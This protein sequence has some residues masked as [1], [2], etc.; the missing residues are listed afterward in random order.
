MIGTEI[1]RHLDEETVFGAKV[2]YLNPAFGVCLEFPRHWQPRTGYGDVAGIPESYGG[3]DGFFLVNVMNGEGWTP[4]E[5]ARQEAFHK[6]KPYGEKPRL[7]K[8][9]VN[10][11]EGY[12][13]FPS[14]ELGAGGRSLL[15]G[16]LPAARGDHGR[17]IPLL[18]SVF[19]TQTQNTSRISPPRCGFCNPSFEEFAGRVLT[20]KVKCVQ[21]LQPGEFSQNVFFDRICKP[22]SKLAPIVF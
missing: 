14:P 8:T 1:L 11:R 12:F 16:A 7:E 9:T 21:A 15:R 18:Y 20:E 3:D 19:C 6:L 2:P 17:E 22:S 10:G 4:E 5:V 13:V